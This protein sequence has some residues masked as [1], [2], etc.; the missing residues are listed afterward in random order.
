MASVT[1]S[2]TRAHSC[3]QRD[4]DWPCACDRKHLSSQGAAKG[5]HTA[6]VQCKPSTQDT[7]MLHGC[8]RSILTDYKEMLCQ[9]TQEQPEL[10]LRWGICLLNTYKPKSPS[11]TCSTKQHSTVT[12]LATGNREDP[13][14]GWDV[15]ISTNNSEVLMIQED[16]CGTET[17]RKMMS[18]AAG[19]Q[20]WSYSSL[21]GQGLLQSP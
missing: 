10:H 20:T 13:C 16:L 12:S 11:C 18:C 2:L 5:E 1:A 17:C 3:Y 19:T 14:S 8:H 21:L 7:E 4:Q 15:A 9:R 6:H